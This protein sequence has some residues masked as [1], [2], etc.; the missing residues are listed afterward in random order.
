MMPSN[1]ADSRVPETSAAAGC[2]PI[3]VSNLNSFA[4]MPCGDTPE[5]V[6]N[7][8]GTPIFNAE[9]NIRSCS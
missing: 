1:F 3:S 2:M 6:P 7:A 8:I 5:S 4:F 9:R